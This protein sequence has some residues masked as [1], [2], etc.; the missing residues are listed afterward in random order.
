MSYAH[1][2]FTADEHGVALIT[3]N[4]PDKR[5]ALSG[6]VVGELRD[7]FER[8]AADRELRALIL[9]GAGEKAFVA[10]ADINELAVL[11]PTEA[12]EYARRG[13]QAF[14]LLETM[15]KPSVAAVN[16][17]ALGGGLELAM[18][19]TVRFASENAK[20]GQP[21]VK[22][23]IIPGYGGT[24]RLPRLVG[25]GRALELL[26]SGEPVTAAE[27]YRIGLVNALVPGEE[28]LNFS[29]AWLAKT[30][31]NAPLAIGLVLEAV[32]VGLDAGL[33]AGLRFEATA[34]GASAA[35]EDS[36]EG[37]RAFLEKRNPA[38]AGK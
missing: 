15:A 31:A 23:G 3:V 1:I 14:R 20:L 32:D 11:T 26:L 29:R 19:C 35:T 2:L 5:N 30:L 28:L 12:R 17:F 21:E 22:L 34:F 33:E 25:R 7:A 18:A 4:R 37:T 24:Q 27:A 16:G 8:V 9:T 36:R 13:Q 6:A 38:F 10:G